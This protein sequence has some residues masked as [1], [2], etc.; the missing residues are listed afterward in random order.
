MWQLLI[1]FFLVVATVI[2]SHLMV[3]TQTVEV[4]LSPDDERQLLDVLDRMDKAVRQMES[5]TERIPTTVQTG[6]MEI[7][8]ERPRNHHDNVRDVLEA[9][10]EVNAESN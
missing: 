7:H 2:T 6:D 5:I 3:P 8:V 10:G 4:H 1:A 9:R